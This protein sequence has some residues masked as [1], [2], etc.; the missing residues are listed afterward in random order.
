M[1]PTTTRLPPRTPPSPCPLPSLPCRVAAHRPVRFCARQAREVYVAPSARGPW[2]IVNRGRPSDCNS[3][4]EDRGGQ[5]FRGHLSALL[6]VVRRRRGARR[7]ARPERPATDRRAARA[8][9]A[10][11]VLPQAVSLLLLPR[12]HRQERA[13]GPGLPGRA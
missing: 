10:H 5:L 3:A 11:P 4:R 6:G 12:L 9:R 1:R 8:L 7:D 13:G 2:G